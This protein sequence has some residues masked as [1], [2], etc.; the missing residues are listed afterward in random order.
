[1]DFNEVI[2]TIDHVAPKAHD[3]YVEAIRRGEPLFN[4]HHITTPLRM[5]HF[6]AQALHE[7]WGFRI[8]RENMNYSA[9]R[10]LQIFG[11][12]HHS[13]A[14]TVAEAAA[15]ANHPEAIADRVYGL[16]NLQKAHELG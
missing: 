12:G 14:V 10:L 1:M 7:T 2:K 3:H 11:A 15:L 5:A 16:G 9:Q 6:L 8:L 13:A 4:D